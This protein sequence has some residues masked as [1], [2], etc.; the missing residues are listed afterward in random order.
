MVNITIRLELEDREWTVIDDRTPVIDQISDDFN[1]V[2]Q[3]QI[4]YVTLF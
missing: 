2:A 1:F 3:L 4:T